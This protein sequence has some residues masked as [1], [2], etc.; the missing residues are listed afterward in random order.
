M[1]KPFHGLQ[2][3]IGPVHAARKP[4]DRGSTQ[5]GS[6]GNAFDTR[7]RGFLARATVTRLVVNEKRRSAVNFCQEAAQLRVA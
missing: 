2:G 1:A 7:V 6:R 4:L 3:D 5:A